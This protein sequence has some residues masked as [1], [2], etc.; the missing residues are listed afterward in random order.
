MTV[1]GIAIVLNDDMLEMIGKDF[2][3]ADK[4]KELPLSS[5][6]RT[7]C[8]KSLIEGYVDYSGDVS[9]V[10][11]NGDV[12]RGDLFCDTLYAFKVNKKK[13]NIFRRNKKNSRCPGYFQFLWRNSI[14]YRIYTISLQ[15]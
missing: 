4:V 3:P 12:K 15:S 1:T 6:A 5:L 2:L 7:L 9:F 11:E 8:D 13:E 10:E 14:R